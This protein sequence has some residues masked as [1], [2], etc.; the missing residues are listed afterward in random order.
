MSRIKLEMTMMDT[1][2]AM[3]EGNPGG[4]TVLMELLDKGDKIDPD[5]ALGG[6]ANVLDLD[7]LG[8]YG[9]RIWMLYKDVCGQDL[10]KTIGVLRAWQLGFVDVGTLNYG[11]DHFGAGLDLDGLLTLVREQL[12]KFGMAEDT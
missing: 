8:I 2:I 7:T 12:P 6:F 1:L 11:I 3:G 10:V 4:L 9:S 5:S